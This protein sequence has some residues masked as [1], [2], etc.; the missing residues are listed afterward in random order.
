M[1]INITCPSD[2]VGCVVSIF[3][4]TPYEI[5]FNCFSMLIL[6][7]QA[8]GTHEIV[9][10]QFAF[11]APRLPP[12]LWKSSAERTKRRRRNFLSTFPA[13]G[14]AAAEGWTPLICPSLLSNAETDNLEGRG[15]KSISGCV[16]P[17]LDLRKGG[18][19]WR[20]REEATLVE[21]RRSA[22]AQLSRAERR[23]AVRERRLTIRQL[24]ERTLTN[25]YGCLRNTDQSPLPPLFSFSGTFGF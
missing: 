22:A 8:W 12:G 4:M 1:A 23:G 20:P 2:D 21:R 3:N 10:F 16:C 25:P 9:G 11:R 13:N 7:P 6:I 18:L 15:R 24:E 5:W 19:A 14:G 17:R